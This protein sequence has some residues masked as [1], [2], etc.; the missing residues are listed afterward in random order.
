MERTVVVKQA[1]AIAVQADVPVLLWGGVGEGK[2]SFARQL[3]AQLGWGIV[4][5]V[6]QLRQPTDFLGIPFPQEL[7]GG[8]LGT[9]YA[10]PDIVLELERIAEAGQVPLLFLDEITFQDELLQAAMFRLV[11]ERVAGNYPLPAGTR[12]LA[13]ANPPGVGGSRALSPQLANRFCHVEWQS[14]ASDYIKALRTGQWE[15][16]LRLLPDDWKARIP[17]A[18]GKMA[19]F[20]EAQPAEGAG[21]G[22][23]KPEE[24]CWAFPTP[25]TRDMAVRLLAACEAAGAPLAVR[26][27]LGEGCVGA[28]EWQRFAQFLRQRGHKPQDYLS[29]KAQLPQDSLLL[30]DVLS[31]IEAHVRDNP[32]KDV[33]LAALRLISQLVEHPDLA[34]PFVR[35]V[36]DAIPDQAAI[37]AWLR[38]APDVADL[39]RQLLQRTAGGD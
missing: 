9:V 36:R 20:L 7:P 29:G 10:V 1:I 3:A 4:T 35:N 33:F 25:R 32:E 26:D 31:R 17:D 12:V 39:I 6:G 13:A 18:A 23:Y 22:A 19:D 2:S 16:R 5:V 24:G 21:I 14:S 34:V 27:V 30:P 37:A 38:D 8:R 28:H 15:F 11:L